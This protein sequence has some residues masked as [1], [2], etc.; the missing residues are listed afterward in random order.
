[1]TVKPCGIIT[2][3]TDFGLKDPYVGAVKGVIYSINR[4]AQIVDIVHEVP[5]FDIA[6]GSYILLTTY[7]EYP[8]GTIN[9]A[10]ID[11]GVGS[12][13]KPILLV[14]RNYFFIGPDNGVLIPAAMDDGIEKAI[15]LENPKYFR[16]EISH[17]F[18]G[19]DIFA[20]V[21]AYL[22]LGIDPE[23]IGE[24]IDVEKLV[25]PPIDYSCSYM[26]DRTAVASVIYIDHF[27]NIVTSCRSRDLMKHLSIENGQRI[28]ISLPH[29]KNRFQLVFYPSFSHGSRGEL[30]MYPGSM[31]FVEIAQY[32]G[33]ASRIMNLKIGDKL[34]IQK[35]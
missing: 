7:R 28:Y 32:M 16:E 14:S 9:V 6:H 21:A 2:L 27:G 3:T 12:E 20:P 31:G 26:D 8:A 13:R 24:E 29:T 33:D 35:A 10:V 15:V 11:P 34:W 5:A 18:H 25:K 1:M 19:R 17:T 30:V 23:E 22:S 4:N